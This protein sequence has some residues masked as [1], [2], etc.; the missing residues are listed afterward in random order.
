MA[1]VNAEKD[2]LARIGVGPELERQRAKLA[3]VAW[4]DPDRGVRAG[5]MPFGGR[6]IQRAGKII[7][8]GVDQGLHALLLEGGA[9]QHGDQLDAAGEPADGRLEHE[10]LDWFFLDHQFGNRVVLVGDRV[11]QFGEGVFG[12]LLE[13]IGDLLD[14]VFEPLVEHVARSPDDRL[15]VH[16][17]DHAFKFV[18]GANRE[19]DRVGVGAEFFPHIVHGVLEVRAGAVHFVDEGDAGDLV[20]GRLAP[21]RFGLRLHSRDSA[22]HG[23]GAIQHAHRALDL[24]S[25]VHVTGRVDDV[26]AMSD[27]GKGLGQ[28]LLFLLRPEAGDGGGGDGNAA[29][30][31]LIHPVRHGIAIIHIANFVDQTGVKENSFGGGRLAGIDVGCN[32]DVAGALHRVLPFRR[33]H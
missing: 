32:P 26:D 31:L 29:F 16:H 13:V 17:V 21:D 10:R 15:L 1:G 30:A 24:R 9:A 12:L 20:F 6:N 2:Q 14:L 11:D 27:S 25:E 7:D 19:L 8:H 18:F 33:V 4:F 28:S 3:L 5:L 22:E 23:D